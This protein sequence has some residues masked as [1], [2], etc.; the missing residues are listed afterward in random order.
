[1]ERTLSTERKVELE[2][3]SFKVK[4][5]IMQLAGEGGRVRGIGPAGGRRPTPFVSTLG[6][7]TMLR[8]HASMS[9]A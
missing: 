7:E 4:E 9:E 3:S 2:P 1:M 8:Q 5:E 6:S